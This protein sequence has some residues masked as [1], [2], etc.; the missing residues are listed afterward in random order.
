MTRLYGFKQVKNC[1]IREL[2]IV[3][4]L[5]QGGYYEERGGE[6]GDAVEDV[7]RSGGVLVVADFERGRW[8]AGNGPG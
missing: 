5:K 1:S 4:C 7:C 8:G 6:R 3:G 2:S